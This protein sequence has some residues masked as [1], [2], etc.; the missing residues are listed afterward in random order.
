M[1]EKKIVLILTLVGF[2][3]PDLLPL[4]TASN[5]HYYSFVVSLLTMLLMFVTDL[6]GFSKFILVG[7]FY[8][9]NNR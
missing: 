5:V 9:K 1:G 6:I 7:I 2:L 4:C 3:C 8:M